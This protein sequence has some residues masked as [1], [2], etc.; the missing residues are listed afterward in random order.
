LAAISSTTINP[1]PVRTTKLDKLCIMYRLL[2]PIFS[3]ALLREELPNF[4]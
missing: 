3:Y 2:L 4:K 1:L